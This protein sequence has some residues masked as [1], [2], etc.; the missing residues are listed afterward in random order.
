MAENNDREMGGADSP[1]KDVI[2]YKLLLALVTYVLFQPLASHI[3]APIVASGI[4][5]SSRFVRA[6]WGR[7]LDDVYSLA[8]TN[9]DQAAAMATWES[10]LSLLLVVVLIVFPLVLFDLHRRADG[11]E[12]RALIAEMRI[13]RIANAVVRRLLPAYTS[14]QRH[15]ILDVTEER[16][17]SIGKR[18]QQKLATAPAEIRFARRLMWVLIASGGLTT[19]FSAS[20]AIKYR[21]AVSIN[22][23][24]DVNLRILQ[25]SLTPIQRDS[26]VSQYAQVRSEKDWKRLEAVM[27]TR[28]KNA[29]LALRESILPLQ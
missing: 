22:R 15:R 25:A 28:A 10:V 2:W 6:V 7:N 5:S 17:D 24:F 11:S 19:G 20:R 4:D 9:P 27:L 16:I 1:K 13:E 14:A 26:L 29:K 8:A 12:S 18:A 3:G 21:L 23:R